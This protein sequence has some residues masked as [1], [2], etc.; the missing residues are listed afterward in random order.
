MGWGG[1]VSVKIAAPGA[2]DGAHQV[3]GGGIHRAM[4]RDDVGVFHQTTGGL[5]GPAPVVLTGV[6][7]LLTEQG[8]TG[9]GF[10]QR[11]PVRRGHDGVAPH[12]LVGVTVMTI[13]L[14]HRKHRPTC[15]A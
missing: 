11:R 13:G 10:E 1:L 3:V 15:W 8:P 14:G 9:Q 5:G 2:R 7:L 4:N 12:P 6:M